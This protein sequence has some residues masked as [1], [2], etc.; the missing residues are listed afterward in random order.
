MLEKDAAKTGFVLLTRNEAR[1]LTNNIRQMGEDL[2]ERLLEAHD[3]EAWRALHYTSWLAYVA[4]EF[5][6][7][8]RRSYQ[9]L[10]VARVEKHTGQLVTSRVAERT[11][12]HVARQADVQ[13]APSA[14]YQQALIEQ[15]EQQAAARKPHGGGMRASV[16]ERLRGAHDLEGRLRRLRE[17]IDG[18]AE[19]CEGDALDFM[20]TRQLERTFEAIADTAARVLERIRRT[21]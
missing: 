2:A 7:T 11:V 13:T 1:A 4:K 17:D 19:A 8:T 18:I 12:Q 10:A 9:L 5:D 14:A 15:R 16:P 21:R 3:G 20:D 6:F